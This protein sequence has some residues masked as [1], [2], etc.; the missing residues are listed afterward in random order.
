MTLVGLIK[1]AILTPRSKGA[2]AALVILA[3][4]VPTLIRLAVEPFV[5]GRIPYL[6]YYPAVVLAALLIEWRAATIVTLGSLVSN[7]LLFEAAPGFAPHEAM[8][9]ALLFTSGSAIL[10]VLG[11]ALRKTVAELDAAARREAFLAAELA[12]RSKNNLALITAMARRC[13]QP[14]QSSEDFVNRLLPRIQALAQAQDL[15]TSRDADSCALHELLENILSPFADHGGISIDGPL[16]Q[17]V[18]NEYTPLVMVIH[19]LATNASKYGALS[20]PD[21]RV[22]IGWSSARPD[23]GGVTMVWKERNGPAVEPP[24]RRGLGTR[25]IDRH[26]AFESVSLEF[27]PDGV[28]CS[29]TLTPRKARRNAIAQPPGNGASLKFLAR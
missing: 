6:T 12:H 5:Q 4:A 14:D 22:A 15:L 17:I 26:P 29:I 18:R 13:Q 7:E 19:E 27:P 2:A 11:H 23:G 20:V 21:G 16:I 28:S 10:I 1:R 25:L 9:R 24:R 8:A 3:I